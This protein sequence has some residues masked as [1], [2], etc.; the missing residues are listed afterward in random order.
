MVSLINADRCTG[1]TAFYAICPKTAIVLKKDAA[2]FTYPHIDEHKC[3]NCG[4]CNSIC[5][6]NSIQKNK[7]NGMFMCQ[8]KDDLTISSTASGGVFFEIAKQF[9]EQKGV[10]IGAVYDQEFQVNH[11]ICD[12]LEEIEELKGSKYIQSNIDGTFVTI[13]HLLDDGRNVCF[14]GTPCQVAGLKSFLRKD[15]RNLLTVD[16]LCHSVGAPNA[17]KLYIKKRKEQL[18]KITRVIFKSKRFGYSFPTLELRYEKNGKE[19]RKNYPSQSDPFMYLF[20]NGSISRE[21]CQHCDFRNNHYS[22]ITLADFYGNIESLKGFKKDGVCRVFCNTEKA[23]TLLNEMK[24]KIRLV[25]VKQ[26][27]FADTMD[28][29][30]HQSCLIPF[31]ELSVLGEDKFF[32]KYFK[33]SPVSKTVACLRL[34]LYRIGLQDTVKQIVRGVRKKRA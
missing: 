16:F 15:Y 30:N 21:C 24:D 11:K 29:L 19:M 5:P 33:V 28:S 17:L 23:I 14:S 26:D 3:I 20:L 4:L 6:V 8:S 12:K 9:V 22:D 27:D 34:A 1:C 31:D 13:K 7:P 18:G 10:V 2:G 25:E 32:S